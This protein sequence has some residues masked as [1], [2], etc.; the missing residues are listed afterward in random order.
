MQADLVVVGAGPGGYTAAFRAA[1][2]GRDVVL[3]ES[4]PTLGGVCLNVGCIPSKALLHAAKVIADAREMS[5][6]GIQIAPPAVDLDALRSWK[7]GIVSRMAG[8]LAS[9]ARARNV[10]VLRGHARYTAPHQLLVDGPDA[11]TVTFEQSIVACGSE[12]VRLPDLPVD[13]RIMNSTQALEL[14]HLPDRLLVVG[15]GVIGLELATVYH[16]LGCRVTVVELGS[17]LIPG[18][19]PDLAEPLQRR[20]AGVYDGVHLDSAVD[21]VVA[22][23]DQLEVVIRVAGS[24][25]KMGFDAMLVA[26]GRR[27]SADPVGVK[28]AGV[29]V[30]DRGFVVVDAQMR[31]SAMSVFAVG[32]VVGQPMLAHKASHQGKVAAEVACGQPSSFDVRCIPSVAYTDP[33]VAWV[34]LTELEAAERDV[35][36]ET[37]TFPWAASG[38][39]LT[40]GRPEG[41]TKL[42]FDPATNR[43]LGCGVVGSSA[44]EIIAEAALAIETGADARDLA[45]TVH[46][47]PTLAETLGLAAEVQE[48][49]VTDLPARPVVLSVR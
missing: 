18:A 27:P 14:Q 1:D 6:H 40:L 29:A 8:G 5:E 15:G 34:G 4:G 26:V 45:L 12:P 37:A 21:Q 47:H 31:T 46:A 33:E 44:S 11:R 22:G 2:L 7:D 35:K 41:L 17:Q 9:L 19:D 49:T 30:D 36:V 3:I 10:R 48:G 23:P 25:R 39:A 43:L 24:S 28:A 20:L 38:R 13:P 42:V 32:D 16:E